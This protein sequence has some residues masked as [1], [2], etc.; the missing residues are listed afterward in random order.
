[1]KRD[2]D[3][4]DL[5]K[6]VSEIQAKDREKTVVQKENKFDLNYDHLK[7]ELKNK[8]TLDEKIIFLKRMER[9][10]LAEHYNSETK[11]IDLFLLEGKLIEK[12]S[13]ESEDIYYPRQRRLREIIIT[14]NFMGYNSLIAIN[15]ERY[16]K[17][18]TNIREGYVSH[19]ESQFVLIYIYELFYGLG[20]NDEYDGFEMLFYILTTFISDAVWVKQFTF[21]ILLEYIFEHNIKI[22][23]CKSFMYF[24]NFYYDFVIY[25]HKELFL[26]DEKQKGY[27]I[28]LNRIIESYCYTHHRKTGS[29]NKIATFLF[30]ELP[31]FLRNLDIYLSELKDNEITLSD[32]LFAK[33][34]KTFTIYPLTTNKISCQEITLFDNIK[35]KCKERTKKNEQNTVTYIQ[36]RLTQ[37]KE[38]ILGY[39]CSEL[40]YI[41]NENNNIP[42]RLRSNLTSDLDMIIGNKH[43]SEIIETIMNSYLRRKKQKA[44]EFDFTKLDSIR[45]VSNEVSEKLI[46]EFDIE[47]KE[48]SVIKIEK[49]KNDLNEWKLLKTK[50][51]INELKILE[52]LIKCESIEDLN[53]FALINNSLLEVIIEGINDKAYDIIDDNLI[54][55]DDINIYIYDEYIE[56]V[57]KLIGGNND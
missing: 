2:I 7:S 42:N 52:M 13:I 11:Y 27:L 38:R 44:L 30:N 51:S 35:V 19:Y 8:R 50:L 29:I 55:F 49:P 5:I 26:K 40:E 20:V 24:K 53:K 36:Y 47:E 12:M 48:P 45:Q 28:S 9:H 34:E 54:E 41:Y 46:T 18:R 23:K 15:I 1:M 21:E 6:I 17:Y 39:I 3:L 57:S 33:E 56:E 4:Q 37:T 16:L 14:N 31:R 43:L 22:E 25:N 10:F 32:I